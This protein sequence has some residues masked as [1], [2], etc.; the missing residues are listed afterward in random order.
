LSDTH[1][2]TWNPAHASYEN[3]Y[4]Q[5]YSMQEVPDLNILFLR[6]IKHHP[7]IRT[8]YFQYFKMSS[9]NVRNV[10]YDQAVS[11]DVQY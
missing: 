4:C 11:L 2:S 8:L 5:L 1:T 7:I 10:Q 9:K 3:I 6:K